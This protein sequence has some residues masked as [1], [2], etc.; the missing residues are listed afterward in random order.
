M[1]SPQRSKTESMNAPSLLTL[2][3]A[4][5]SVP[6]N[7]SKTPP[8][9]TT[10][11][12]TIQ[13][14][15]PTRIAP[16]DGDAEADEGQAVGREAGAAHAPARSARRS[17]L[18]RPR[19]S[20]EMVIGVS[21]RCPRMARSRAATSPKASGR[22]VQIVSRP[23]RRVSTRPADAEA[24]EVMADERLAEADVRDQL[25]DARLAVGEAPD[26]A[27][28][29]HVG[30]GLVEG[31]QV[32]QVLGLEDDRGDGRADPGGGRHGRGCSSERTRDGAS[33]HINS[34]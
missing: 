8:M 15:R 5:A 18:M 7:M 29:V 4:R 26:D 28:P 33:R 10:M 14:W 17:L 25:G 27:Q 22:R 20:L 24:L 34:G 12:P 31:A 1:V 13:C 32:A 6:S 3:V 11:P 16:S 30:E 21:S 9:K 19:D 23:T 2:P